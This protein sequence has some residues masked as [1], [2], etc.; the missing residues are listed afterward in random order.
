M[1]S[2][3]QRHGVVRLLLRRVGMLVLLVLVFLA[4]SSVW[5][6]YEKDRESRK[7]RLQ[8]EAEKSDLLFRQAQLERGVTEIHTDRGL[9][10]A[11]REQYAFAERGEKLIVIVEPPTP[12]PLEATSTFQGWFKKAFGWW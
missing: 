8:A 4:S 11:L 10:E 7:L 3:N 12:A 5:S 1:W 9:E 6:V 2:R